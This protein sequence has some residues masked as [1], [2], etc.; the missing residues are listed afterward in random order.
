MTNKTIQQLEEYPRIYRELYG[1]I[2]PCRMSFEN[3]GRVRHIRMAGNRTKKPGRGHFLTVYYLAGD[4]DR[5]VERFVEVNATMLSR[6]NFSG[7]TTLDSGLNREMA[8][9]IR[10]AI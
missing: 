7:N 3:R 5:A 4:E 6:L 8:Q 9:K 10:A 1:S 2:S